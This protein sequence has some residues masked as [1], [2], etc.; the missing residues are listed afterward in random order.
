MDRQRLRFTK[1]CEVNE[2]LYFFAL[3]LNGLF[4]LHAGTGEARLLT[5]VPEEVP[6]AKE[7][8][9]DMQHCD[10]KLYGIPFN[11]SG[12]A[13]Y[14]LVTGAMEHVRLEALADR[15]EKFISSFVYERKIYM[16]P[17]KDN[18]IWTFDMDTKE[19]TGTLNLTEYKDVILK[20]AVVLGDIAYLICYNYN[21]ILRFHLINAEAEYIYAGQENTGFRDVRYFD[22][23]LWLLPVTGGSLISFDIE[24]QQ[25]TTYKIMDNKHQPC[26]SVMMPIDGRLLLLPSEA[27]Q[28]AVFAP[29]TG[30][31]VRHELKQELKKESGFNFSYGFSFQGRHFGISNKNKSLV[32]LDKSQKEI[33]VCFC[34]PQDFTIDA[35]QLD[36]LVIREQPLF[37]LEKYLSVLPDTEKPLP[38][39]KENIGL[40]IHRLIN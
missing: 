25:C 22:N 2:E 6:F 27:G 34:N 36:G 24:T 18:S 8:Y 3:E 17:F 16:I 20:K 5:S 23:K 30:E 15:K 1:A 35:K 11:A 37:T 7:L 12:M 33:P 10:N 9:R 32:L 13:I 28:F 31:V 14:N 40:K 21:F 29:D 19:V 39:I 4:R 26:F 38:K